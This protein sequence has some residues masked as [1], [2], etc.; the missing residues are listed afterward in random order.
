MVDIV[1]KPFTITQ[2]SGHVVKLTT[3]RMNG[4]PPTDFK[5]E[6]RESDKFGQGDGRFTDDR[7]FLATI[8]W[9]HGPIGEYHGTRGDNGRFTGFVFQVGNPTNAAGWSTQETFL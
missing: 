7:F 4:Q 2:S 5:I 1:G 8:T 6:A 9:N 3:G